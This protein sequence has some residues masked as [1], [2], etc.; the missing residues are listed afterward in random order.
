MSSGLMS[1]SPENNQH[2][3]SEHIVAIWVNVTSPTLGLNESKLIDSKGKV[4]ALDKSG[5]AKLT[6]LK[7]N[8][9]LKASNQ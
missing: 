2:F 7:L 8:P 5:I 6:G 4:F 3:I 9:L 1:P